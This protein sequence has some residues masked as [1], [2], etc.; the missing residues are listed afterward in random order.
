M[1]RIA[2]IMFVFITLG[3]VIG[4]SLGLIAEEKKHEGCHAENCKGM[5]CP[6]CKMAVDKDKTQ[7]KSEYKGGVY[8]FCSEKCKAEFDKT[9]DKYE[10]CCHAKIAYVCPMKEC[11]VK[12]DK[13]GKCPKCGMQLKKVEELACCPSAKEKG[14]CKK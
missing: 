9:P 2:T 5:V 1:K 6:I 8:Y 12:S 7:F 10:K 14:C 3:L 11:N 13:E 4:G